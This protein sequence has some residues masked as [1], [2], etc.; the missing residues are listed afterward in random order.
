[1]EGAQRME[2]SIPSRPVLSSSLQ[3]LDSGS[4]H[5]VY[6]VVDGARVRWALVNANGLEILGLCD[7]T[8]SVAE[9]AETL[10]ARHKV[11]REDA[12]ER[13][14]AFL[15]TMVQAGLAF[16]GRE[17]PVAVKMP[18]TRFGGITVEI[19]KRCNLRCRHCYLAA[20]E[21][22][23]EELTFDEIRALISSA[24]RLG[25]VFVNFSGGEPL[26]R[27][28]CFPLLEHAAAEGLQ[29]VIG[30]NGTT[31]SAEVAQRL[32]GLPVIVQLSMDGA[33]S[34]THDAIRGPGVFQRTL[35]G[36]D[37]LLQAGLAKQVTLSFTP[38][39]RNVG[40]APAIIDLALAKGL[41]KVIF[42]SLLA[43]GNAQTNWDDL[44]LTT[45]QE[46]KLW[47]FVFIKAQELAGRLV[48]S[49][50]ALSMGLD[51]PGRSKALCSIG[52]N[53]RITP[54]GHVYPCQCFVGGQDYWLGNV[55]KKTLEG[56]VQG[57][58]L[59]QIKTD[60]YQ[61]IE[62]IEQCRECVWRHF[63]GA[64]CM[65]NAYHT[66]GTVM[67]VPDCTLRQRW[68]QRLFEFRIG[69]L[70]ETAHPPE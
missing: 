10:A 33:S 6:L 8:Q 26:L 23:Q 18:V 12:L 64:G 27:Q 2:S 1:M 5:G 32:A 65:G 21:Q 43:G 58:R 30:T 51:G 37:N 47:E 57:P 14:G 59:Q 48:L 39:A 19:T 3:V 62:R 61:R 4:H 49:H 38:T 25:A 44:A 40:D 56:I 60:C 53:L 70:T 52:T 66:Q 41:G 13:A 46:F 63:C 35:R 22:A 20:G 31:V 28:D 36:L 29:C 16:D 50:Q 55:R 34:A 24:A 11:P 42:T 9:I 45:E 69:D 17:Q 68:I 67:A 7:G 15:D 54:E